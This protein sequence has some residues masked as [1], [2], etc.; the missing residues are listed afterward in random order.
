MEF[1]LRIIHTKEEYLHKNQSDL[2]LVVHGITVYLL[3]FR[4]DLYGQGSL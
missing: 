4:F 1:E 2:K 3:D